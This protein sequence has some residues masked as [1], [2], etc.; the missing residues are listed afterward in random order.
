MPPFAS[1][2][3]PV[4]RARRR[5]SGHLG[6]GDR[7]AVRVQQQRRVVVVRQAE[8]GPAGPQPVEVQ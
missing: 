1:M 6:G 3:T 8:R 5:C 4:S 7:L 2:L